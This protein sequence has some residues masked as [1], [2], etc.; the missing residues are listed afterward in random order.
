MTGA[1]VVAAVLVAV[2]LAGII[3]PVLPGLVMIWGGVA[4]WTFARRDAWGWITLSAATVLVLAGSVVKY[5]VPGRRLRR[6]G[7]PGRS[8]LLGG[9]LGVIGFLVVPV[10]GPFLG[11]VLGIYLSERARLGTHPLAWVSTRKA[12]AATGWSILIELATGL[13]TAALW[14]LAVATG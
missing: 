3:V 11:F 6:D 12:L 2:G 5:L 9:I 7:I 8:L 1:T 10:V 13:A 14:V 4:V